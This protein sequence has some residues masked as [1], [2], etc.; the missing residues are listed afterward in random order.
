[1]L[2]CISWFSTTHRDSR[3]A[4]VLWLFS[5]THT[6]TDFIPSESTL[7]DLAP[8]QYSG[9]QSTVITQQTNAISENNAVTDARQQSNQISPF[10][11]HKS[12]QGRQSPRPLAK[13]YTGE[14]WWAASSVF[15][16]HCSR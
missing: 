11:K 9:Q 4:F 16:W 12:R 7:T 1:M 14:Q 13:R 6:Q 2:P 3:S 5:I 8:T 10:C 15:C